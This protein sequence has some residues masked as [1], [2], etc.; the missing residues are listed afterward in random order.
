MQQM[1]RFWTVAILPAACYAITILYIKLR[2]KK[3]RYQNAEK[4]ALAK[5]IETAKLFGVLKEIIKKE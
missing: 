2:E 1:V 3:L 5:P 4:E